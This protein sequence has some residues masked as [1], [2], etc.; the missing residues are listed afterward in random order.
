[1]SPCKKSFAVILIKFIAVII[2]NPA[3]VQ[4]Q[5][6][7]NLG[8][9]VHRIMGRNRTKSC[10]RIKIIHILS[11]YLGTLLMLFLTIV[12]EVESKGFSG[13]A[14]KEDPS[15]TTKT[16]CWSAGLVLAGYVKGVGPLL[17]KLAWIGIPSSCL[18]IPL[19]LL[20]AGG[21]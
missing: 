20:N 8:L 6:I 1:M 16:I 15:Q 18:K 2:Q 12:I 21:Y 9:K 10:Y 5:S 14:S 4:L 19:G 11:F 17:Y 13:Y 3:N 7:W